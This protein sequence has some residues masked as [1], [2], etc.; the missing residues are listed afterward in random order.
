MPELRFKVDYQNYYKVLPPRI[1][2]FFFEGSQL[3]IIC[4]DLIH[5]NGDANSFATFM[6]LNVVTYIRKILIKRIRKSVTYVTIFHFH[7][8]KRGTFS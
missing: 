4:I 5:A 1:L 6:K 7:S 3:V 2:D 8:A